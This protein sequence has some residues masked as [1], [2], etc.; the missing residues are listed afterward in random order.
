[1]PREQAEWPT[2]RRPTK[3]DKQLHAHQSCSYSSI[4]NVDKSNYPFSSSYEHAQTW[5]LTRT[6]SNTHKRYQS[7]I[8]NIHLTRPSSSNTLRPATVNAKKLG[9]KEFATMRKCLADEHMKL[10][11]NRSVSLFPTASRKI[12]DSTL[13]AILANQVKQSSYTPSPIVNETTAIKNSNIKPSSSS[14]KPMRII[15]VN[16]EFIVRI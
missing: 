12:M 2:K 16:G 3:H 5:T 4:I 6:I 13:P 1:M 14:V 8:E 15:H 10:I 7:A 9:A 11:R